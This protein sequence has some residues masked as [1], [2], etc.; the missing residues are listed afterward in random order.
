MTDAHI[1]HSVQILLG[2]T[3]V[4][5]V[6]VMYALSFYAQRQIKDTEDY[7]VAGRRLPLSLAWATLLA[8]WFG[9]GTILTVSTE[10]AHEG[11]RKAAL[12]P[13]GAG[14]CLI[15]AGLFYARPLWEMGLLTVS[16][17]FHRK[18]GTTAEVLSALIMIPSYFGWIAAQ[19]VALA[20]ML[21]LF[22]GLP[23]ESGIALVALVGTGYTL[24]GGMWAVTI[25][26]A[27]QISLVLVGLVILSINV[28]ASAG[29]GDAWQGFWH[30]VTTLSDQAPEKL[31]WIPASAPRELWGWIA[32]LC[33]GALG[34]LA[35]QDL[36]QRV[37]AARSARV[38]QAA[39][40][41]AGIAY[42]VFGML[43]VLMGLAA[44]TLFGQQISG[45]VLPALAHAFMHPAMA[46]TFSVVL[47][48][49]VL[50]TI[51]SAILSP[52]TVLAQNLLSK[53]PS[54]GISNLSLNRL[55]VLFIAAC[56][57]AM[58]YSGESA[59]SLLEGA[60]SITMVGLFVPLTLGIYT[61]PKSGLPALAAMVV[62]AGLWLP[63]YLAGWDHFL[64]SVTPFDRW[65]LP[66]S[67]TATVCS[68]LAYVTVHLWQIRSRR[69][70][71]ATTAE[72]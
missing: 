23:L 25:T 45:S 67:L 30:I 21:H 10:V 9:A 31:T 50:S 14:L 7:V 56:S 42:L 69:H 55:C 20:Q 49:A 5:Y 40:W 24:M 6:G 37:F 68:L 64:P 12:D 33:A 34:N 60:Y 13:I 1:S 8:T 65:Q 43:P 22:F 26:D 3:I 61:H 53:L 59:Y 39:C 28:L 15:L 62:G 2:V 72:P 51:D 58:A 16:D 54:I 46:V 17:F 71:E 38:A 48:S 11:V 41:C 18:F 47:M 44:T 57:L 66:L 29:Q 32:V 63:Q 19:F 70:E 35:G 27:L 4:L 36:L 52:A